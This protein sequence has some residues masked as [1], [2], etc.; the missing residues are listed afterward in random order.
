MRLFSVSENNLLTVVVPIRNMA[1]RLGLFESW[2]TNIQNLPILVRVVVDDSE[3]Q[4]LAEVSALVKGRESAQ[5]S[6]I[7]GSFLSPGSSRNAGLLNINTKW[8]AFWDSDDYPFTKNVIS[9][10]A[11]ANES[12]NAIVGRFIVN[13]FAE[14]LNRME[15]REVRTSKQSAISVLRNPGL[16]RW[17]FTAELIAEIDFKN[18]LMG[19]DQCFLAEVLIRSP[20]IQYSNQ[21]FYSY[22]INRIGSLTNLVN[23]NYHLRLAIDEISRIA[24]KSRKIS[25]KFLLRIAVLRLQITLLKGYVRK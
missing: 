5:V 17:V 14:S 23:R 11:L 1:S 4:T 8:V 3:D 15:F 10:I 20:V 19:E 24:R 25:I 9:A 22:S 21:V 2:L 16:W 12:T 6:I 18:Y 7:S 13:D